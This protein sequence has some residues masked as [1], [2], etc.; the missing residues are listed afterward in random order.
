MATRIVALTMME[1]SALGTRC[2]RMIRVSVA[3]SAFAASM[4]SFSRSDSTTP[5]ATRET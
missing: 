5:R 1:P 2:R 4:N 3:P